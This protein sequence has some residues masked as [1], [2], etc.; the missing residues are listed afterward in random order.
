MPIPHLHGLVLNGHLR[1]QYAFAW[2]G[3]AHD[4]IKGAE[5]VARNHQNSIIPHR[6]VVSDLAASEQGEGFKG[7]R[8]EGAGWGHSPNFKGGKRAV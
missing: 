8:V 6:V 2:D 3:F 5:A 4:H 1:Q 7:R